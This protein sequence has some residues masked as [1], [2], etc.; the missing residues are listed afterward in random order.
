LVTVLDGSTS[1]SHAT[2]D[3]SF[4]RQS[5]LYGAV[6]R[7]ASERLSANGVGGLTD[8]STVVDSV[9]DADDSVFADDHPKSDANKLSPNSSAGGSENGKRVIKG[10]VAS[11]GHTDVGQASAVH[12][13]GVG[14][15]NGFRESEK[16]ASTIVACGTATTTDGTVT[17]SISRGL[18]AATNVDKFDNRSNV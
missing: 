3:A 13:N 10:I 17:K 12:C 8:T 5:E 1:S 7:R 2:E 14:A 15:V 18:S 16:S 4:H 9:T 11:P 6:I